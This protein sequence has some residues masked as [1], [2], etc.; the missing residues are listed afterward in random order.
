MVHR[1]KD[2][3]DSDVVKMLLWCD[4][5]CCICGKSCGVNIEIA[6]IDKNGTKDIDNALPAC[7]EC[8]GQI[9][10]YN[11]NHPKGRKFSYKERKARRNQIYEQYTHHLVPP[12]QY[13][14]IQ[15]ELDKQGEAIRRKFPDVG[16]VI[17][18]LGDTFP[19]RVTVKITLFQGDKSFKLASGHY[20]GQYRWNLNPRFS[21]SGHFG[22]PQKILKNRDEPLRAK[23]EICVLDIYGRQHKLLPVGYVHRLGE[24]DDWYH[25]PCEEELK[26][27]LPSSPTSASKLI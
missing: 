10:H 2:F 12:L 25:E 23:I 17:T 14:L 15:C 26:P 27:K 19:V 9:E 7:Y 21:V 1:K 5:H 8:H 4:R 22:I 3:A 18:H 13:R 6:H 20:N 11:P 16:F 24:Q